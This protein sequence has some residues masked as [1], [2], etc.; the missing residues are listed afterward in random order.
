MHSVKIKL[1]LHIDVFP[2]TLTVINVVTGSREMCAQHKVV[3]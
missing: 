3:E 1:S 2:H